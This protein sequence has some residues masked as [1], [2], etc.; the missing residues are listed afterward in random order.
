MQC[1]MPGPRT[2][3]S[4]LQQLQPFRLRLRSRMQLL[5]NLSLMR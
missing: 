3:Q 5:Q 2:Q 4:L 1:S